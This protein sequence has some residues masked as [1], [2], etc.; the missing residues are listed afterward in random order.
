[1]QCYIMLLFLIFL[2]ILT[3]LC[4]QASFADN[5]MAYGQSSRP[6]KVLSTSRAQSL[7]HR[8]AV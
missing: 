1:M 3:Y 2:M 5:L 8:L 6:L 4:L 7:F